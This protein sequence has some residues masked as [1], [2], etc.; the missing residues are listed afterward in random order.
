MV[1]TMTHGEI[2][3][4]IDGFQVEQIAVKKVFTEANNKITDHACQE[5]RPDS[6]GKMLV[7]RPWEAV[8]D[9]RQNSQ[10]LQAKESCKR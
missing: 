4:E 8:P 2:A 1:T 6:R 7:P 9:K 10:Q 5:D 3:K